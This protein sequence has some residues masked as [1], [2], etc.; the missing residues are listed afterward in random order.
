MDLF[1]D[2]VGVCVY[3][4]LISFLFSTFIRMLRADD[5]G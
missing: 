1:F 2:Y 3:G 4:T 5:D